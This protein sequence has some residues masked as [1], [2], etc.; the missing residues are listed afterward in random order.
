MRKRWLASLICFIMLSSVVLFSA[1]TG[2]SDATSDTDPK[3]QG[4][5]DS[6]EEGVDFEAFTYTYYDADGRKLLGSAFKEA[7]VFVDPGSDGLYYDK[8]TKSTI[9]FA[10]MAEREA[11]TLAQNLAHRLIA[12]YGDHTIADI[13]I[14]EE[15]KEGIDTNLSADVLESDYS[16]RFN[17]ANALGENIKENTQF[18]DEVIN[19]STPSRYFLNDEYLLSLLM[20]IHDV[21]EAGVPQAVLDDFAVLKKFIVLDEIVKEGETPENVVVMSGAGFDA[22]INKEVEIIASTATANT[23][24]EWEIMK[25]GS[26]DP[27]FDVLKNQLVEIILQVKSGLSMSYENIDHLGFTK[28]D[29]TYLKSLIIENIIGEANYEYDMEGF[30]AILDASSN[31]ISYADYYVTLNKDDAE[32]I[33]INGSSQFET[34]YQSIKTKYDSIKSE[35]ED[36]DEMLASLGASDDTY[37][38][39]LEEYNKNYELYIQ[40][41]NTFMS[42]HVTQDYIKMLNYKG[43]DVALDAMIESAL[44]SPQFILEEAIPEEGVGAESLYPVFPRIQVLIVP[45]MYL[46]GEYDESME[47]DLEEDEEGNYDYEDMAN[48]SEF[49]ATQ[50]PVTTMEPYLPFWK[51][52]SIVY[53]PDDVYGV[54]NVT[55]EQINGIIIPD[56]DIAFVGEV[57]YTSMIESTISYVV[58]GNEV[59]PPGEK[60]VTDELVDDVCPDMT[61]SDY[62]D[63]HYIS[64][65]DLLK[66]EKEDLNN[67]V[68]GAYNGVDIKTLAETNDQIK[69]G[70]ITTS[71]GTVYYEQVDGLPVDEDFIT[72]VETESGNVISMP[73]LGENYLKLDINFNKITTTDGADVTNTKKRTELGIITVEPHTAS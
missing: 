13:V 67:Y 39:A 25:L 47:E 65:F 7:Y 53:K 21:T 57:G 45:G 17:T 72:L 54:N 3:L 49:D 61:A 24:H 66:T 11:D 63:N 60:F 18:K 34:E 73:G 14:S 59:I 44:N 40:N 2:G 30:E 64:L 43:Y 27:I 26:S 50:E 1:C 55:S 36:L 9:T 69:I 71:D 68:M 48:K 4:I 51:I 31:Q 15:I 33:R 58:G 46:G 10:D 41:Y 70:K 5:L 16:I 29:L 19:E 37:K 56:M 22:T 52:L 42:D 23:D 35:K 6:V 32:N 12:T 38:A 8:K 20:G 62:P 28:N